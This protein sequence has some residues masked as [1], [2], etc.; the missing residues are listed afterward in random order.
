MKITSPSVLRQMLRERGLSPRRAQGQHF[1][2]DE[3]ILEKILQAASLDIQ[4]LVIDIGAGPGA[5]SLNMAE[6][7]N[8]VIAIEKDRGLAA[9][10]RE[11]ARLRGL[12]NLTVIEGD[13]RRLDLES[14]CRMPQKR[15][16]AA[17]A[18]IQGK[19]K[20]VANL[21]YYL[22][23]PLLFQ[24]LQGSCR[25]DLL[26]LMVQL[27]VARRM[28]AEPGSKD[29][30][31]LTVLCR[32]YCRSTLLFKVSRHVFFP[33]PE[34]DSAVVL[35]ETLPRPSVTVSDEALFWR[36][37]RSAFQKRRK[38]LLNALEGLEEMGRLQWEQTLVWAGIAPGRRGETLSPDEFAK[39]AELL[40]NK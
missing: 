23:T 12:A 3:N 20:V 2:V 5:L 32:Y 14:L 15:C 7:V 17:Q 4:D 30:G 9:F 29:Y 13:V 26:V 11:Q 40:Y 27:E 35:L 18:E 10:L 28:L 38:T 19:V 33:Q 34:V 37:V 22:T 31:T 8:E 24:L 36:M 39:I 25:P 1:L 6:R 16:C 21:P